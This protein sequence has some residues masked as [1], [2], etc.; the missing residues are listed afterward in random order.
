MQKAKKEDYVGAID[1]YN[2][3]LNL[4]HAPDDIK[5]MA[6]FNRGLA[7]SVTKDIAKARDDLQAVI[8]MP[9]APRNVVTAAREKL[10]R[11]K[12]REKDD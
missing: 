4:S 8:A 6:L 7:F 12:R 9:R 10:E 1:D 2:A 5:A 3:L 11:I